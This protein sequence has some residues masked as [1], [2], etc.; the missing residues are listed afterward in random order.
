MLNINKN[1]ARLPKPKDK[2]K[3]SLII[4]ILKYKTLL[5]ILYKLLFDEVALTLTIS[6]VMIT[7]ILHPVNFKY[8]FEVVTSIYR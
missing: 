5:N 2:Y 7:T 8:M 3:Y 4:T 6:E 1:I